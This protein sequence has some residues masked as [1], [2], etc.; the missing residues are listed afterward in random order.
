MRKIV[1]FLQEVSKVAICFFICLIW[2][3]YFFYQKWLAFLLASIFTAFI[4][5]T[6][7]IYK[8]KKN[9][10]TTLKIKEKQ[11]AEDMFVSLSQQEKPMDFFFLLEKWLYP[12]I[13][14]A[15]S[16]F[17]VIIV[18]WKILRVKNAKKP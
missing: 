8:K 13:N 7:G 14:T 9:T 15:F 18:I 10:K 2:T 6:I 3:R 1:L 17:F 16:D 11:Q 5:L 12:F 4:F